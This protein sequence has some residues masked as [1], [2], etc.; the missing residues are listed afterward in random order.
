MRGR[1]NSA[2]R[3]SYEEHLSSVSC[4]AEPHSSVTLFVLRKK[5]LSHER[6][7]VSIVQ[8]GGKREREREGWHS[9]HIQVLQ[10]R[11]LLAE[12]SQDRFR[13]RSDVV[14]RTPRQNRRIGEKRSGRAQTREK[15]KERG[16]SSGGDCETAKIRCCLFH[17]RSSFGHTSQLLNRSSTDSERKNHSPSHTEIQ[18]HG[19]RERERESKSQRER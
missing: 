3:F 13:P 2:E 10:S 14:L 5:A 12:S 18:R 17:S 9:R 16:E 6:K 11:A 19:Q 8:K 15:E 4:N 1:R 7:A